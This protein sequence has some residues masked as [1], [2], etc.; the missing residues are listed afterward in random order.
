M[1]ARTIA[2]D[3]NANQ[4]LCVAVDDMHGRVARRWLRVGKRDGPRY[5]WMRFRPRKRSHMGDSERISYLE[6]VQTANDDI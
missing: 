6:N 2:R 5:S 1:L 4:M 3:S